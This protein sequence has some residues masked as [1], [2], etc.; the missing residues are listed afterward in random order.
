MLHD[1]PAVPYVWLHYAAFAR[2][3]VLELMDWFRRIDAQLMHLTEAVSR[4]AN[5]GQLTEQKVDLVLSTITTIAQTMRDVA[6]ASTGTSSTSTDGRG[7][8]VMQ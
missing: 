4:V 3:K 6:E 2:R 8:R 7:G 5:Q 1:V